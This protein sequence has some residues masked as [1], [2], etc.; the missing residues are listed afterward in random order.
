MKFMSEQEYSDLKADGERIAKLEQLL[1][2]T[3]MGDEL[4]SL[5]NDVFHGFSL[6]QVVDNLE[7]PA[8]N[9]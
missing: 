1:R 3:D 9:G 6:R 2:R 8:V 7:I 4:H 5:M